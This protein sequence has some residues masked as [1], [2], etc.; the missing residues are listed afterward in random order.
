[1]QAL[2]ALEKTAGRERVEEIIYEGEDGPFTFTHYPT[3]KEYFFRLRRRIA[4]ELK[5]CQ[6]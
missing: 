1:M 2:Y 3:G 6:G 4:E 5:A